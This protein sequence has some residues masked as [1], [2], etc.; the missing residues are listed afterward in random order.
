[1]TNQERI[2]E[3]L[4]ELTA[5]VADLKK[6]EDLGWAEF[7]SNVMLRR[8]IERTLQIAIECALD[9]A[10]LAIAHLQWRAAESNRDVFRVFAEHGV[11]PDVLA[12]ELLKAASFRNILV[13]GYTRV[14]PS[15]VHSLLRKLPPNLLEFR[16]HIKELL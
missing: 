7:S 13:H 12:G 15:V 10:N 6:S 4:V 3:K 11:L 14:E 8:G 9:A 5:Y 2:T 1:L 16:D